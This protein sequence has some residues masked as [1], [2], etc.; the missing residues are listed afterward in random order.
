MGVLRPRFIAII[1]KNCTAAEIA[2]ESRMFW[3]S[4][5]SPIRVV[6]VNVVKKVSNAMIVPS[7]NA[8]FQSKLVVVAPVKTSLVSLVIPKAEGR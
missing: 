6:P 1:N 7:T 3:M 8:F 2:A 5:S 4:T